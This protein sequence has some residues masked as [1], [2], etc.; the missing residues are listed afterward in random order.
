MRVL[1]AKH[2]AAMMAYWEAGKW[3]PSIGIVST[4]QGGAII[5]KSFNED[6]C[7]DPTCGHS[8]VCNFAVPNESEKTK[9]G[10]PKLTACGLPHRR[11]RC[12]AQWVP[13]EE[14]LVD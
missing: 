14:D 9:K 10:F 4:M 11:C 3:S 1:E 12:H 5:C 2:N 6:Q 8:H 13:P 7:S